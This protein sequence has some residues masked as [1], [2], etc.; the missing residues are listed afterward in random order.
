[1]HVQWCIR[2]VADPP[3]QWLD[4]LFT[5]VGLICGWWR[6]QPDGE[7]PA[8]EI[9]LRLDQFQLDLHQNA[10]NARDP[11]FGPALVHDTTPFISLSAGAVSREM[12]MHTN[13]VH[14]AQFIAS[15]FATRYGTVDG[16]LIYC[17][18]ITSTMPAVPIVG[19]AEEVR[20]LNSGRAY[21]AFQLEGEVAAKI[22]VP[23]RQLYAYEPVRRVGLRYQPGPA[24]FNP[25]FVFP[26]P[27][28]EIRSFL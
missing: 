27:L 5:S 2:G 8:A 23:A 15:E 18:V 25:R 14:R 6:A 20:D 4:Q 13:V 24:V 16:V 10:F 3:Q 22:E 17:W 12:L 19:V 9:Q 21:S 26:D 11:R 1:V 28:A 7:L